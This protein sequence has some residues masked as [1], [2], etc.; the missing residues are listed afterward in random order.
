MVAYAGVSSESCVS[1]RG[2]KGGSMPPRAAT[3]FWWT[4]RGLAALSLVV[5]CSKAAAD[6]AML[7]AAN[8]TSEIPVTPLG[9]QSDVAP[10]ISLRT[11][12]TAALAHLTHGDSIQDAVADEAGHLLLLDVPRAQFVIADTNLRVT[13]TAPWR[14]GGVT[15]LWDPVALAVDDAGRLAVLDRRMH[16][17]SFVSVAKAG[18][19]VAW[20]KVVNVDLP[21]AEWFC[22]L[23]DGDFLV[24]GFRHGMR[25]N[26]VNGR[27]GSILRSF[28]PADSSLHEMAQETETQ[29][30]IACDVHGDEV[31]VA[32]P[33]L[34]GFQ[35]YEIKSGK[36]VGSGVLAPFRPVVV[37]DRG[38]SV[39]VGFGAGGYTRV[40]A[41][42]FLGWRLV[43][44]ATVKKYGKRASEPDTVLTYI[45]SPRKMVDL[46]T[47][48]STP[49]LIPLGRNRALA[50]GHGADATVRFTDMATRPAPGG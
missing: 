32:T 35:A 4:M 12:S 3:R 30:H 5:G 7:R 27:T 48:L 19:T 43:F 38:N 40:T 47:D 16:R 34:A 49:S 46:E 9:G 21:T 10:V 39:S 24:Y 37:I 50:I 23:R 25:L 36:S 33:F 45:Y 6:P 13:G 20:G 29:G 11:I 1:R 42:F 28:A 41:V 8:A 17:I 14:D 31:V 22:P 15:H 26:L 2:G 44:Q 18:T